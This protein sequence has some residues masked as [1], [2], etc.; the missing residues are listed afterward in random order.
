MGEEQDV[1]FLSCAVDY[2]AGEHRWVDVRTLEPFVPVAFVLDN[3][4]FDVFVPQR[5]A[6][7]GAQTIEAKRIELE[8]G[9]EA[10]TLQ[11]VCLGLTRRANQEKTVCRGDAVAFGLIDRLRDLLQGL[12]FF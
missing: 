2:L 3:A 10:K 6:S 5:S 11:D 8:S 1:A 9:R 12:H 7:V 4:A